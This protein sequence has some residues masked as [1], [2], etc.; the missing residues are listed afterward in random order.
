MS[1]PSRSLRKLLAVVAMSAFVYACSGG[2]GGG[3]DTGSP[4]ADSASD[5]MNNPPVH[6]TK[7]IDEMTSG[8]LWDAGFALN[9]DWAVGKPQ[10]RKC[11]TAGTIDCRGAIDAIKNFTPGPDSVHANGTIVARL[12]NFGASNQD[13][14]VEGRYKMAFA[15]TTNPNATKYYMVARPDTAGGWKWSVRVAV[16]GGTTSPPDT[17]RTGTWIVCDSNSTHP[18]GVS[19]F[20]KCNAGPGAVTYDPTDPGWLRCSSGCCTAGQ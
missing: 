9:G 17:T 4:A 6:L 13:V 1:V 20:F 16:K 19:E 7:S 8:E 5:A 18:T 10:D 3:S 12:R 14:G 15:D 2:D 11:G